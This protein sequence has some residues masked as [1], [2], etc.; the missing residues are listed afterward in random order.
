M[1][2]WGLFSSRSNHH[3]ETESLFSIGRK[4]VQI[5]CTNWGFPGGS[6]G[7]ESAYNG[8]GLGS[9]PALGRSPG[10]GKGSPLRYSGLENPWTIH[11]VVKNR[12]QLSDFHSLTHMRSREGRNK[13]KQIRVLFRLNSR[14]YCKYTHKNICMKCFKTLV[15]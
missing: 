9:I 6:A 3:F 1:Q 15:D 5:F 4:Q 7:K 2:S 14:C 8:G 13:S 11:G 12:T 10:E